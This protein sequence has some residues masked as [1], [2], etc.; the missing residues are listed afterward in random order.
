[1]I[2][3]QNIKLPI[4]LRF[5]YDTISK[6]TEILSE[7]NL[8]FTKILVVSGPSFSKDVADR[9]SLEIKS[10]RYI[11][12]NNTLD[13]SELLYN[14]IV[15]NYIDLVIAVGGG[16]VQDMV[17][18]SGFRAKINQLIIPTIISSDGLISPV[19]V[20]KNNEGI[21]QSIGVEM[22]LGVIIDLN[23]IGNTPLKYIRAAYGDLISNLSA[24]KDWNLA[25]KHK[26]ALS[27]DF[28][29][30]MSKNAVNSLE[31]NSSELNKKDLELLI[32]GL[33]NSGIAM[34]LSGSS[35][36]CSGSE[37]ALSHAVDFIWKENTFLHG[38][39]VGL[40][41]LLVF[42]LY[43]LELRSQHKSWIKTYFDKIDFFEIIESEV[44]LE[45]LFEK[46]KNIRQDRYT[47][48]NEIEFA[49]FKNA[50]DETK[51]LV[52][53]ILKS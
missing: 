39:M 38:E 46:A 35:R 40:F 47:I 43:G 53:S 34:S 49:E 23:I 37:H 1:M 48:L 4:V 52:T 5:G 51:S 29:Y 10:D 25:V 9:L 6:V 41:S 19:A 12:E 36:P 18:Y 21:N 42:T 17:K 45:V 20:L 33:V 24:L 28:A 50:W 7:H 22:P 3:H 30:Q 31:I 15:D 14:Y 8:V 2:F 27:N 11:L 16:K 44:G 13:S 32:N 26:K